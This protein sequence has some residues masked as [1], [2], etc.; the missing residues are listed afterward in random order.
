MAR[1]GTSP[2]IDYENVNRNA[3]YDPAMMDRMSKARVM[4]QQNVPIEMIVQQTGVPIETLQ[5]M[6]VS[7]QN[8][9]RPTA[10]GTPP[11]VMSNQENRPTQQ[12]MVDEFGM[13][14]SNNS[15]EQIDARF[16][17][18]QMNP[19]DPLSS[20]EQGM[21]GS[22]AGSGGIPSLP[23]QP[24]VANVMPDISANTFMPANVMPE[25]VLPPD[26]YNFEAIDQSFNN[27][28]YNPLNPNPTPDQPGRVNLPNNLGTDIADYLTDELGFDPET[29]GTVSDPTIIQQLNQANT[30]IA[31]DSEDPNA[32]MEDLLSV[33]DD[34]SQLSEKDALGVY[35]SALVDFYQDAGQKYKELIKTPDE[36]LPFLVAGLSLIESGEAGDSWGTALSKSVGEYAVAKKQGQSKY[37]AQIQDID[38][39]NMMASDAAFADVIK[40]QIDYDLKMDFESKTGTRKQY[41]VTKPNS[42]TSQIQQLTS[43]GVAEAIALYGE[44]NV[45]EYDAATA[46]TQNNYTIQYNDGRTVTKSMSNADAEYH[47]QAMQNGQLAGFVKAGVTG[48]SDG[49]QIA[50]RDKGKKGDGLWNFTYGDATMY[51]EYLQNSDYE[52]RAFK[53]DQ[54]VDVIDKRDDQLKQISMS[55]YIVNADKFTLKGDTQTTI[56]NGD[57]MI[58]LNAS[59]I[60]PYGP[61]KSMVDTYVGKTFGQFANRKYMTTRIDETANSVLAIVDGM[62]NPDNAFQNIGGQAFGPAT[63]LLTTLSSLGKAFESTSGTFEGKPL[64]KFKYQIVQE[65]GS[66]K[67][68][69]YNELRQHTYNSDAWKEVEK[70]SMFNFLSATNADVERVKA[71]LFTLAILSA[72][73]MGGE[74]TVDMR[75]ISDKD[76]QAQFERVGRSAR[77]EESFRGLISDLK[78]DTLYQERSYLEAQYDLGKSAFYSYTKRQK[79]E[80]SG[81]ME[82]VPVNAWDVQGL[83]KYYN[84]RIAEIEEQIDALGPISSASTAGPDVAGSRTIE[85]KPTTI[86][87]VEYLPGQSSGYTISGGNTPATLGELVAYA[88][89]SGKKKELLAEIKAYLKKDPALMQAFLNM[90]RGT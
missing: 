19:T 64:T 26:G 45:V 4:L 90:Y 53:P 80:E 67:S 38:I 87:G 79:N 37:D 23:V 81:F 18:M 59:G 65:D 73:A 50:W 36:G 47:S 83:N 43:L 42:S 78:R 33:Q 55:Q 75:A 74:G 69:T 70:S 58:T 86:N 35:R 72:G 13:I 3:P 82:S 40:T 71:G 52:V 6:L 21:L 89:N 57:S 85:I 44:G 51:N 30:T 5:Q 7:M 46:G 28:Q 39:Q 27:N 66:K 76:L 62:A 34:L 32:E 25:N 88:K 49:L 60:Q 1:S 16:K 17:D 54:E 15:P 2:F 20:R 24:E 11:P 29:G 9:G 14:G 12:Q 56:Q 84:K 61:K 48:P 41:I 68:V 8:I 31:L 77:N 10:P 63:N 22:Y